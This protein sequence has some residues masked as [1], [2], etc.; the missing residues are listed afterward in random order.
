MNEKR[1]GG[2]NSGLFKKDKG[3]KFICRERKK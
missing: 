2:Q 3:V 1:I